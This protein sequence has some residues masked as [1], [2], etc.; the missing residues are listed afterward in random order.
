M[1][2]TNQN[3]IA[4]IKQQLQTIVFRSASKSCRNPFSRSVFMQLASC[5]TSS[6]GV[7]LLRCDSDAC[8]HQHYQYH[9]CGNRHCLHPVINFLNRTLICFLKTVCPY[10]I[11]DIFL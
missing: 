5:R 6:V 10:L 1:S 11:L 3:D 8:Q 9:N 2:F 4:V 7:H